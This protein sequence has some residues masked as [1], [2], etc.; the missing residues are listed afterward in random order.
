MRYWKIYLMAAVLTVVSFGC[1]KE[2]L[3]REKAAKI[4]LEKHWYP[5]PVEAWTKKDRALQKLEEKGWISLEKFRGSF[6][7]SSI[8]EKGKKNGIRTTTGRWGV[9]AKIYDKVFGEVTGIKMSEKGNS[10]EVE[11][12]WTCNNFT[13]FYKLVSP[14]DE[15]LI[16]YYE[17][18]GS[19]VA[20]FTLY[21][22]GWRIE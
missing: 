12:T 5:I 4:I 21:D 3:T 11:Y 22:D 17:K 13:E 18:Q 7:V 2:K 1:G 9:K 20:Y 19:K 10:A 16:R 8:R 6:K 15:R 14:F